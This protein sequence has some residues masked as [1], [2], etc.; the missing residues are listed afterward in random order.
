MA[1]GLML[2]IPPPPFLNDPAVRSVLAALPQA[3]LVGGCVRDV[4]AGRDVHDI[5]LA[6]PQ[7]PEDVIAALR[8]AGLKFAPTGLAHGTVTAIADHRGFEVTTLRRD[9]AT[10]G[11]HAVVAFTDDWRADAARRDFTINALSLTE[12]GEVYDYF[13]GV[14]DL[15]AGRV[16]FVGDAAPRIREDYLRILRFFRFHARFGVG[17]PDP[18]AIAAIETHLDGLARLSVER[19]W[20]ELSRILAVPDPTGAVA[21]MARTGVL[22]AIL[23]EGTDPARLAAL[24]QSGA[25]PDPILRLAALLTG[26]VE[27]LALRLRLSSVER[28]ML[29]ALRDAPS[30]CPAADDDALRRL[31]ADKPA[32][33]LIGRAWLIGAP[34][35]EWAR[36]RGRLI[37]MPRPVFPLVG[38][39][40]VALGVP[41][42]PRVGELL[43]AVRAW[44]LTGGCTADAAACCSELARLIQGPTP[45]EQSQP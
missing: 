32:E 40:A 2:R 44:W 30:A 13:G 37:A 6:T 36:L 31:L 29:V 12:I 15:R 8:A 5:D 27:A 18:A 7:K 25:P 45:P 28:T 39:H 23:P 33:V 14:A 10:D 16:R 38:R 4:L 22:A 3:R 26:D 41:A 11:R 1:S 35:E 43:R 9:V 21:L 20:S 19:V 17:A 42:G 34:T 24:M